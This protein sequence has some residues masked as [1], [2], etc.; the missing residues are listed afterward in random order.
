[1]FP[2]SSKENISPTTPRPYRPGCAMTLEQWQKSESNRIRALTIKKAQVSQFQDPSR[3]SS[4]LPSSSYASRGAFQ[5]PARP[6]GLSALPFGSSFAAN[7]NVPFG[8][9]SPP[10]GSSSSYAANMTSATIDY[11]VKRQVE[12]ARSMEQEIN[13]RVEQELQRVPCYAA[14][15]NPPPP[16]ESEYDEDHHSEVFQHTASAFNNQLKQP[17]NKVRYHICKKY[18]LI[19]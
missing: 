16:I 6:F 19:P 17:S 13:R 1:M 8:S 18:I 10:L 15:S 14:K 2:S 12:L 4:A 7:A 11:E 5:D 9:A 3:S